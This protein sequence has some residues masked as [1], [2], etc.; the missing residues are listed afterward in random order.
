MS[1]A[2]Q[3][4]ERRLYANRTA[5]IGRGI[6]CTSGRDRKQRGSGGTFHLRDSFLMREWGFLYDNC[7]VFARAGLRWCGGWR[8]I[9]SEDPMTKS[10]SKSKVSTP[11]APR[12]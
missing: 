6:Y 9:I 3:R 12:T 1:A 5:K 2:R 8:R 10:K 11:L 4:Y 7:R